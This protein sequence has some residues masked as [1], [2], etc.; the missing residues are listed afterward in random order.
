LT[1][2]ARWRHLAAAG[3]AA[4]IIAAPSIWFLSTIPPLWRDVDAY[5]Q[6]TSRPGPATV[7]L[8]GPLYGFLARVPL[9]F[10]YWLEASAGE[11]RPFVDF[12]LRPAL[13]DS[14][15]FAL[16]LLQ[17]AA[18]LAA[19]WYFVATIAKNPWVRLLLAA[20]LAVNPLLYTFAH[21]VG[22]E[23]LSAIGIVLLA[24]IGWRMLRGE[25]ARAS[26]WIAF[27]AVLLLLMLT[28]QIN[29]VLV[30]LLPL[31]LFPLMAQVAARR[32]LFVAVGVGVAAV[33]I[34]LGAARLIALA[35]DVEYRS[36]IGFTFMWRLQFL[37]KL[38]PAERE[39][40]VQQAAAQP[41]SAETK[42]VIEA[43]GAR[44]AT[45]EQ[46][47]FSEFVRQQR[48]ALFP[49]GSEDVTERMDEALNGMPLAF[50]LGSPAALMCSAATDFVSARRMRISTVTEFLFW[51]TVYYVGREEALPQLKKLVTF[52]AFSGDDIVALPARFSYLRWWS[53]VTC[54]GWLLIWFVALIALLV[55][56]RRR[57]AAV[58]P[59]ASYAT[60]LVL[61]GLLIMLANSFF[62]ELL[63]RYTA[64]MFELT[65][66]S[67]V[68]LIG[69]TIETARSGEKPPVLTS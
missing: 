29:A 51:S 1:D 34:S 60:A 27:G 46:L 45:A 59:A 68:L 12:F 57:G 65:Y 40:V 11:A 67:L 63:P 50:A 30:A 42:A 2:T 14:G 26:I 19:Q 54:D 39:R 41:G 31:A 38:P 24:T 58:A 35:A 66:L 48:A 20:C 7:L 56:A 61:V 4:L 52:R 10:G 16:L 6:T 8:H 25:P 37:Q 36:K 64:P 17:Q 49:A 13:T 53:G 3:L 15:V 22:S 32:R 23:T 69:Q 33:A 21:C 62:T 18:L 28:R 43:L 47:N 55:L 44:F 9:Y 5:I